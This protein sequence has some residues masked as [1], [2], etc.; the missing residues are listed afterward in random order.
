MLRQLI[1]AL[2]L[3]PL[4][5]LVLVALGV[6]TMR[7][8]PR[9]GR[10]LLSTG[11]ILLWAFSTPIVATAL[12]RSLQTEAAIKPGA[13]P[14]S[15]EAIVVLSAD[16][17]REAPEYGGPT[18]GALGLQR[19]R[20]AASL[21][22][23]TG[24]P[25]LV[26]GGVPAEG[27]RQHAEMMK[28]VLERDFGVRV[29]W[30]EGASANTYENARRSA[31]MLE[32]AGVRRVLLV[33]HAWHMPRAVRSF[34]AFGIQVFPAPTGFRSAPTDWLGALVPRWTAMRDSG[35]ALHEMIGMVWYESVYY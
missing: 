32:Q 5:C 15:A 21:N 30:T 35:L 7:R 23:A 12:L 2:L 29:R 26:S 8:K 14:A 28:E 33:T 10:A 11:L 16:M 22:R 20:Y 25:V 18:P 9:F 27:H 19:L 4:N 31:E 17:D 24:K 34:E 3:P 1:E 13:V 6:L